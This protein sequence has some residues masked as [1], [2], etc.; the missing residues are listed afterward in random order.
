MCP[1]QAVTSEAW[2]ADRCGSRSDEVP[3]LKRFRASGD[4]VA[5]VAWRIFAFNR[6]VRYNCRKDGHRKKSVSN[7]H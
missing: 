4:N 5:G 2:R 3:H 6:H 1:L 7:F